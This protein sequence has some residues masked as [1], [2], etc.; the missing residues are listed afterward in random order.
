M[1]FKRQSWVEGNQFSPSVNIS[2][3]M[4]INAGVIPLGSTLVRTWIDVRFNQYG[5]GSEP[6][7]LSNRCGPYIWGVCYVD[8]STT[9]PI[10]HAEDDNVDWLWRE[11]VVWDAP[12]QSPN[13]IT[14]DPQW[15]RVSSPLP[16][17]RNSKGQRLELDHHPAMHF[18]MN[19]PTTFSDTPLGVLFELFVHT[20]WKV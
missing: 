3:D 8:D 13:A 2:I 11:M 17:W 6:P 18:A 1:T 4:P 7:E 14:G 15:I 5:V 12:V 10:E 9:N 20:L 19:V 16:G